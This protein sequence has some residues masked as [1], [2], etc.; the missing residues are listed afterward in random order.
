MVD[1]DL[2]QC[3]NGRYVPQSV[4]FSEGA[5]GGNEKFECVWTEYTTGHTTRVVF[6]E[7]VLLYGTQVFRRFALG[8]RLL[9][10][11]PEYARLGWSGYWSGDEWWANSVAEPE[12]KL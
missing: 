4:R 11:N 9:E 12:T 1:I 8:Q 10:F 3:R 6:V 7:D 5:R 2:A